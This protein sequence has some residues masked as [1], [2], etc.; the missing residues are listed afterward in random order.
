MTTTTI[1]T[2]WDK[3][4]DK[5]GRRVH[6][7][8]DANGRTIGVVVKH[9]RRKAGEPGSYWWTRWDLTP[10][11]PIEQRTSWGVANFSTLT[12]AKAGLLAAITM[13]PAR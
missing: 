2:A 12:A 11:T 5:Y 13:N 3:R 6:H 4:S 1:P 8:T 10:A 9:P 7:L